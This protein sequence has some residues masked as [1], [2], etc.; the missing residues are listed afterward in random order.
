LAY[1]NISEN[2]ILLRSVIRE[3]L[4]TLTISTDNE[5]CQWKEVTQQIYTQIKKQNA[6]EKVKIVPIF[7]RR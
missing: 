5:E 4:E 2:E 6:A 7:R 1:F 3:N